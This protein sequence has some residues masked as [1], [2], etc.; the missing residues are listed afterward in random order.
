VGG[1]R[2]YSAPFFAVP[3]KEEDIL[4]WSDNFNWQRAGEEAG[5]SRGEAQ[6]MQLQSSSVRFK[7]YYRKTRRSVQFLLSNGE[8][9]SVKH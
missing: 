1:G 5:W 3:A 8:K 2:G 4:S 7:K 9:C 6:R